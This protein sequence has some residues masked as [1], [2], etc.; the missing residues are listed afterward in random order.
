MLT[1]MERHRGILRTGAPLRDSHFGQ[2]APT[3]SSQRGQAGN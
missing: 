3:L 1:V 2:P